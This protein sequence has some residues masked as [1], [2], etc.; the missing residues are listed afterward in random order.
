MKRQTIL[1]SL[2][3]LFLAGAVMMPRP[4]QAATA[5]KGIT[6][7]VVLNVRTAAALYSR[8]YVTIKYGTRV[9]ILGRSASGAW[10]QIQFPDVLGWV[11]AYYVRFDNPRQLIY[12]LPVV[13]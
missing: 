1:V 7:A 3:G 9:T 10:L 13:H 11:S 5:V 2:L 6:T 8:V 4:V 12:A